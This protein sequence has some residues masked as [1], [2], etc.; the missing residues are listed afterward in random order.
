V[1]PD[2]YPSEEWE[3]RAH[4]SL[5]PLPPLSGVHMA[6]VKVLDPLAGVQTVHVE[7]RDP[8]MG[9]KTTFV[10]GSGPSYRV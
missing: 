10:G 8:P 9:A 7:V 1:A 2:H 5:K 3:P 6:Y 4:A